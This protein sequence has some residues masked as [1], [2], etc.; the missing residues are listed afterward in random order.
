MKKLASVII[1]SLMLCACS[2][3][4]ETGENDK[5]KVIATI[6]PQYDFAR[7]VG[8]EN[9]DLKLL[10]APGADIHSYEPSPQDIIEINSCD[11]FIYTG[12]ESDS[13]VD[14]ILGNSTNPD[15]QVISLMDCV[16]T[17]SEE[18]VDGMQ[19]EHD[20][21]CEENHG[22]SEEEYDE[23]VWTSPKNA[24]L[25]VNEIKNALCVAD[26]ENSDVYKANADAY[27]EKLDALDAA[28]AETAAAA[29]NKTMVFGDRFPF[30]YFAD[31]YG[32]DY[33]A[34]FPGCSTET[35]ASASTIS[36]L[37]D[38]VNEEKIPVV[39]SIELSSGQIADTICEATGAERMTFHSCHNL[40]AEDFK[41]GK[42]YVDFMNENAEALK[43][44]FGL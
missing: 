31:A 43:K 19:H 5:V 34:A 20:E 27:A 12:G 4:P 38:K 8:G 26:S 25:I 11:I 17:V 2:T 1:A 7:A 9:I 35:S 6:F 39:F 32:I 13:W 15:M 21:H 10:L 42:T 24:V 14:G 33:Y 44:A 23:H 37:I 30:R 41:S 3:A 29:Q 40:T 36:F 18:T 28:F 22:H 16:D